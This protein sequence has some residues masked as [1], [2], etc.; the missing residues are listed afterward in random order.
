MYGNLLDLKKGD[1]LSLQTRF[2]FSNQLAPML[3]L[4]VDLADWRTNPPQRQRRLF[5]FEVDS[6]GSGLVGLRRRL[7]RNLTLTMMH[8]SSG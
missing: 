7:A 2:S 1:S 5:A 4:I 3:L 6:T 8:L